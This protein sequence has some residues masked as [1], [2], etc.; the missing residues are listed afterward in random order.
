MPGGEH[1]P[2]DV[3]IAIGATPPPAPPA[4]KRGTVTVADLNVRRGPG[5]ANESIGS[6]PKGI[7][8]AVL[9][10]A[11]NGTTGWSKIRTPGGYV[12]WVASKFVSI[13]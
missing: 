12:G 1:G 9:G 6:L 3:S 4:E 13:A 7:E 10:E 2:H 5:V 8:V 11:S